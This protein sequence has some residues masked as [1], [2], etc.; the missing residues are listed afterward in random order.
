MAIFGVLVTGFSSGRAGGESWLSVSGRSVCVVCRSEVCMPEPDPATIDAA[1]LA[2]SA[3]EPLTWADKGVP[4]ELWGRTPARS[5]LRVPLSRF[6]TPLLT[7]SAPALRH[8][9]ADPGELVRRARSG[10]GAARQDHDGAPAV[11]RPA[12]R[13]GVGDH[14][15]QPAAAGGRA[16]VRGVAGADRQRDHLA[17]VA[18]LD[19]RP[20]GRRRAGPGDHLGRRPAHGG[21]DGGGAGGA[22]ADRWAAPTGRSTCSS[23]SAAAVAAPVRATSPQPLEIARAIAEAPHLRLAGVG[24]YEAA[25]A[26]D[27]DADEPGRRCVPS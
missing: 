13:R 25:L 4:P 23:S 19:R 7:L 10:S 6:P 22:R 21:P 3:A 5:A 17:A 12:G 8:N 14:P 16:G 18:A 2:T 26:A 11:G 27:S 1:A 9:V 24:G 20:A 15:G